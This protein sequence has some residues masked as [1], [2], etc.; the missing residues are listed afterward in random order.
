MIN[1]PSLDIILPKDIAKAVEQAQN[2]QTLANAE[3]NRLIKLKTSLEKE[4]GTLNEGR[5]QIEETIKELQERET[6]IRFENASISEK[7]QI[8]LKSLSD[9][10]TEETTTRQSIASQSQDFD[11][12]TAVLEEGKTILEAKMQE[13]EKSIEELQKDK[14]EFAQKKTIL[15]DA[16]SQ[17]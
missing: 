11:D 10:K 14:Q 3:T 9:A 16:I 1:N 2:N 7:L 4:I 6:N 13:L 12:K 8:A 15:S 17:L 5:V